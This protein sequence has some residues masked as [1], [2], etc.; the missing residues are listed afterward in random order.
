M[1]IMIIDGQGGRMGSLLTEKT[2]NAA[3]PGAQIY[4]IGTNSIATA[5]M[6]KAGADYGATGE[7][8]VLVNSR[9]ADYIIGPLG[10]MAADSLLGEVTPAMAVAVGQSS[11]MK[12]LLPVNKCNHHVVGVSSEYS[13][14]E[15]AEQAV[16]YLLDCIAGK[17]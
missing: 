14:S 15:L 12:I 8:P 1:K 11:A 2:K 4:A 7:N 9:D 13:M 3:I 17:D 5:A 10:I 16:R 6:L